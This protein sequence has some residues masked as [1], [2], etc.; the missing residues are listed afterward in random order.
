MFKS[1]CKK[2]NYRFENNVLG[3]FKGLLSNYFGSFKNQNCAIELD[4]YVSRSI[5]DVFKFHSVEQ[6]YMHSKA[7]FFD[8]WK[9]VEKILNSNSAIECRELG[10]K[11]QGFSQKEWDKVKYREMYDIVLAKFHQNKELEEFLL[12]VPRFTIFAECINDTNDKVWATGLSLD[13]PNF[14]DITKW[15]GTNLMGKVLSEVKEK[16]HYYETLR[17]NEEIS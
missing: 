4:A 17:V 6:A 12:S 15:T 9:S 1:T 13:N 11:I 7:L 16:L 2:Y 3:Y 5:Y 14:S 8:D 10:Q